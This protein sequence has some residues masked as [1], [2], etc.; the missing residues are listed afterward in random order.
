MHFLLVSSNQDHSSRLSRETVV[1]SCKMLAMLFH[2]RDLLFMTTL[3]NILMIKYSKTTFLDSYFFFHFSLFLTN[4]KCPNSNPFKEST[5][6]NI[7]LCLTLLLYDAS[8]LQCD[9]ILTGFKCNEKNIHNLLHLLLDQKQQIFQMH[10]DKCT[11][12]C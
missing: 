2:P 4:K 5:T 10:S 8:T 11:S 6:L 9:E 7:V 12:R 3:C 1:E